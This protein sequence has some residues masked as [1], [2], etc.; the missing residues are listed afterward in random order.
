MEEYDRGA[1]ESLIKQ[2]EQAGV[3]AFE[4]NFSCPHG[5]PERRMGMAMGQDCAILEVSTGIPP[6]CL[7]A[8][9]LTVCANIQLKDDRNLATVMFC[10]HDQNKQTPLMRLLTVQFHASRSYFMQHH[11]LCL[12]GRALGYFWVVR[13]RQ[14]W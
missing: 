1:W 8:T 5:L 12:P 11:S 2:C 9:N 10:K 7:D 4:V 3:D 14:A 6:P 13:L